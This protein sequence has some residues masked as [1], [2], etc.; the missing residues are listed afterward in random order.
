M[1]SFCYCSDGYFADITPSKKS[2]RIK[3]LS[4]R[5]YFPVSLNRYFLFSFKENKIA[6]NCTIFQKYK[7][8]RGRKYLI[9]SEY[10][11]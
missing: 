8:L 3:L 2:H 9:F 7:R 4:Y 1:L 10:S 5:F 11:T 6:T